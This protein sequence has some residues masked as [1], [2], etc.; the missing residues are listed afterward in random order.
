MEFK[1]KIIFCTTLH[2]ACDSNNFEIIK[3]LIS[4]NRV[5]LNAKNIL[6][7]HDFHVI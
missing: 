2:C 4:L 6:N 3:Y 5:D 7:I 1:I